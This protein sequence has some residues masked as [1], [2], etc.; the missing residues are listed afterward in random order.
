MHPRQDQ[1]CGQTRAELVGHTGVDELGVVDDFGALLEAI[2]S[3]GIP[4][5]IAADEVAI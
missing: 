4:G 1:R 2:E 3:G 5:F